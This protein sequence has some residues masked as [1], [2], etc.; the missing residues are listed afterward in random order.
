MGSGKT[1]I[2]HELA[3][4]TG[5]K[6]VD[7][8]N[9]VEN[10]QGTQIKNIFSEYGEDFFRELE[11]QACKKVASMQNCVVS[12]GGG[13][14]TYQRNVDAVKNSGKIIFLDVDFNII[15]ERIGDTSTRPLFQDKEKAKQLREASIIDNDILHEDYDER[16]SKYLACADIVID[17]NKSA[18][19]VASEIAKMFK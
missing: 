8:D 11:Y 19:I 1:T 10:E 6:F 13:A 3:R 12:T 18:K 9:M 15:C 5:R 17:G 4:M 14:M 16:K 7:T 2:G